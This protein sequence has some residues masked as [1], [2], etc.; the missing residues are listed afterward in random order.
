[1]SQFISL[2]EAID[3][4][5]LYRQ[6]KEVILANQFKGQNI[7]PRCETFH[8]EVFDTLLAKTGCESIRIYYG[9]DPE[10]KVHAIVVAVNDHGED[11]LP[12]EEASVGDSGGSIGEQGQRCPEDCPPQ[13]ALNP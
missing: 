8:R 13:S 11:I 2:Q 6:D 1:M 4:T 7:L 12:A 3:M 9:M 10:K 5:T